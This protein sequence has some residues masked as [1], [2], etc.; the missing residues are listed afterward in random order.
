MRGGPVT[1][2]T[3]GHFCVG[4]PKFPSMPSVR[5]N[6]A[7]CGF[8]LDKPN[9]NEEPLQVGFEREGLWQKIINGWVCGSCRRKRNSPAEKPYEE[10][11]SKQKQSISRECETFTE[12]DAGRECGRPKITISAATNNA[13][14]DAA[15][16]DAR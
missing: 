15:C 11:E 14:R 8:V 7:P 2:T 16:H 4:N 1:G 12:E 6:V 3:I 10:A 13:G 5:F 9:W